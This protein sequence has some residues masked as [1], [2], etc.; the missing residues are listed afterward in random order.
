MQMATAP[1]MITERELSEV[2]SMKEG[3]LKEIISLSKKAM[4]VSADG[5]ETAAKTDKQIAGLSS[6]DF[7]PGPWSIVLTTDEDEI[8]AVLGY[9]P[10]TKEFLPKK[11]EDQT[12][13]D[14]IEA[15]DRAA[16][17]IANAV[18]KKASPRS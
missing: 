16:E 13:A 15:I 8:V 3:Q 9:N 11:E 14:I 12:D 6:S 10:E 18:G 17:A 7:G 1:V 5:K 4:I 2:N